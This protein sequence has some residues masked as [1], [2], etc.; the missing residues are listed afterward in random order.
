MFTKENRNSENEEIRKMTREM[1]QKKMKKWNEEASFNVTPLYIKCRSNEN[2]DNVEE[3]MQNVGEENVGTENG[4]EKE[5][6]IMKAYGEMW[7]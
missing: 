4:E 5:M 1:V 7:K 6:I 3:E 2:V